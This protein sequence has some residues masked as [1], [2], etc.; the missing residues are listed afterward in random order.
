MH[1]ISHNAPFCNRN[2]H[3]CAHFCYKMVHFG[4]FAWCIVE[5]VRWVYSREYHFQHDFHTLLYNIQRPSQCISSRPYLPIIIVEICWRYEER[6]GPEL[7]SGCIIYGPAW[8][9]IYLYM[10]INPRRL[11]RCLLGD[12]LSGRRCSMPGRWSNYAM[13]EVPGKLLPKVSSMDLYWV[14]CFF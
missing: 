3:V 5:S 14:P 1:Q 11:L 7:C 6:F 8:T 12:Y 10:R 9:R 2:L 13:P 4:I